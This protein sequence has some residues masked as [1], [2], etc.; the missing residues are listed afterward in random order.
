MR[1]AGRR[2]T[3]WLTI[4]MAIEGE[5]AWIQ[6]GREMGIVAWGPPPPTKTVRVSVPRSL[7]SALGR[8]VQAAA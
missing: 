1:A 6:L 7:R 8:Y 5:S 3:P 2:P 4:A